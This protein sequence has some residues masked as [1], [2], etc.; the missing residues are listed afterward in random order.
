[1]AIVTKFFRK[2]IV[3]LIGLPLLA[4]GLVL[5]PLPGPGILVSLAALFILSLEFSWAKKYRDICRNKLKT[6][7]DSATEKRKAMLDDNESKN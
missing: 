3:A 1:M 4:L 6:I 5:I 2:I 7:Y